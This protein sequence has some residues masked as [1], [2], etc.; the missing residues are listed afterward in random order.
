MV[1]IEEERTFIEHYRRR[2]TYR[3]L[4]ETRLKEKM[5]SI[6]PKTPPPFLPS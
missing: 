6:P 1:K 5:V 4:K 3:N 2:K